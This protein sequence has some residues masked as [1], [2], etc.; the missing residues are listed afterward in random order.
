ME[1]HEYCT[2]FP[3]SP[4]DLEELK[5]D[6]K[7]NGLRHPIRVFQGKIL[8][9]RH[10]YE[11]CK[12]VGVQPHYIGFEGTDEDAL[13]LVV[14]ENLARRHLNESQRGIVA[15]KI[16]TAKH[17]RPEK[18]ANL[19]LFR[20]GAAKKLSVSTRTVASSRKVVDSGNDEL[21]KR[22]ESGEMAVS[23]A[24]KIATQTP[25]R[26]AEILKDSNPKQAIKKI[27]RSEKMAKLA[28]KDIRTQ[29]ETDKVY[30]VIYADPPWS[31]ET[32][33]ENGK[34]RAADNH[35]PVMDTE[36]IMKLK[37]PAADDCVLFLWATAPML[38]QA[39]DVMKA[40]GFTY[41]SHLIWSKDRIGTGYWAR[42]KHE[43]L[44]IG[45]KGKIPP[46]LPGT[47]PESV[48]HA[49]VGKHS[50]KPEQFAQLIE[51]LFEEASKVD[52]F[53]RKERDGWDCIG[54]E[55]GDKPK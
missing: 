21:L 24:A 3:L 8:D 39:L 37:A 2:L 29:P 25:E 31:F 6:I 17:G 26:Q 32:R 28:P 42:N 52:M 14:S 5:V 13:A 33:S 4:P 27:E 18:D 36:A 45:T 10:R 48:I 23:L 54:N 30:S 51:A 7:K 47:Q 22:V 12:A 49:P 16:E 9:G 1:Y 35:Y 19:H 20:S 38:P 46:P 43:L 50:E 11:A 44:L 15:A 41:K 53:S 55:I 34:D 40:W